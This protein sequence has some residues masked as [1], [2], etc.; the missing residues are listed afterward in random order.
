MT[1]WQGLFFANYLT[2]GAVEWSRTIDL[3][4]TNQ[5]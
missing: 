1:A 5:C 4:I 2:V 3:L